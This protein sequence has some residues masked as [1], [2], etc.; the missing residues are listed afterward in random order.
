MTRRFLLF[1]ACVLLALTTILSEGQQQ[2]LNTADFGTL[3]DSAVAYH[4]SIAAGST[5][6]SCSDGSFSA[7]DVGKTVFVYGSDVREFYL[8]TPAMSVQARKDL[9][10]ITL[11]TPATKAVADGFVQVIGKSTD[12][13]TT[14]FRRALKQACDQGGTTVV[15]PPGVYSSEMIR[16]PHPCS[17]VRL[18]GGNQAI[19]IRAHIVSDSPTSRAYGLS[20][21]V[22]AFGDPSDPGQFVA[23]ANISIQ[24]GSA[25]LSCPECHWSKDNIGQL[26]YVEAAGTN[27]A[28]LWAKID[29]V[30][31]ASHV[32][33]LSVRASSSLPLQVAPVNPPMTIWGYAEM[34]DITI[35]DIGLENVSYYFR[36][37]F[38]QIAAPVLELGTSPVDVKHGMTIRN[39]VIA[40][41]GSGCY[42][43]NGPNDHFTYTDDM[44]RGGT[45]A[46]WYFSGRHS[47][48]VAL[49]L[50]ADNTKWPFPNTPLFQCWL[51]KGVSQVEFNQPSGRC[52]VLNFVMNIADAPNFNITIVDPD[53]DG[54]GIAHGGIQCNF[55][56]NLNISGG[57]VRNI[58]H[59]SALLLANAFGGGTVSKVL[60]QGMRGEN[61]D[62]ALSVR[63]ASGSGH[64]PRDITFVGNQFSTLGNGANI[65]SVE[66]TNQWKN[67]QFIGNG[68]GVP[69][70]IYGGTAP[71]SNQF[72]QNTEQRYKTLDLFD[73]TIDK[74]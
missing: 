21:Q 59:G 49:R 72:S 58:P 26:I 4:C 43:N 28:P 9:H 68:K 5:T 64:G 20:G 29:A 19:L 7:S 74:R 71:G 27:R 30:D 31:P 48:G 18:T 17:G 46:A 35:E 16:W 39:V 8:A 62:T 52:A 41:A 54:V 44:C 13:N 33:T 47:N 55:S 66:G 10:N 11:S 3:P 42:G 12:R 15:V 61:I 70:Q 23:S 38:S 24:A 40:S 50:K 53:L 2:V 22:I 63:D 25:L 69:W 1:V 14:A 57:S 51:I 56:V 60:I 34:R 65:R 6:L 45:D 36:P 32:A 37:E 67:N 73:R